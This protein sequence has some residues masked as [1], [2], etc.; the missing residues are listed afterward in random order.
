MPYFLKKSLFNKVDKEEKL[1]F[2][3][4]SNKDKSNDVFV[5]V[6]T[7]GTQQLHRSSRV[8]HPPKRYNLLHQMNDIFLLGD[9]DHR[10]DPPS[11]EEAISYINSKSGF[12]PWI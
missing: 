3:E 2:I 10:D 7:Q 5:E 6:H 4:N 11:C 8:I 9:K 12:K 1:E